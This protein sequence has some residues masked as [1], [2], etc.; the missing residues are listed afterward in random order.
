VHTD[1]PLNT[2]STGVLHVATWIII[3]VLYKDIRNGYITLKTRLGDK[4]I[5]I[6]SV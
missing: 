2:L 3:L 5:Y 6:P 4:T 1:L